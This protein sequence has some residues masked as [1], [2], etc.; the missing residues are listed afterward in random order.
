MILESD[1]GDRD[2]MKTGE[3]SDENFSSD[4]LPSP[5]FK[6]PHFQYPPHDKKF[7]TENP[8]NSSVPQ[9]DENPSTSGGPQKER[10]RPRAKPK[11]STRS[12]NFHYVPPP[13]AA[14]AP[15]ALT[16]AE[17]IQAHL[18]SQTDD[19]VISTILTDYPHPDERRRKPWSAFKGRVSCGDDTL[20]LW[21]FVA[22]VR[23]Y[24]L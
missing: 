22:M 23:G 21:K 1:V 3:F 5:N 9:N 24:N 11:G 12:S 18:K 19:N 10:P 15:E 4:A 6:R 16:W 14:A 13:P 7:S 20:K 2:N 8:S 17:K